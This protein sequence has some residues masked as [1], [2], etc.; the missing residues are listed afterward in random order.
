[1]RRKQYPYNVAKEVNFAQ[2][3]ANFSNPQ[4]EF[5]D[6]LRLIRRG[7]FLGS[8][9]NQPGTIDQENISSSPG[10]NQS[11]AIRLFFLQSSQ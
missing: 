4:F 7:D 6:F 5:W 10:G 3:L 9:C 11:P 8:L 1:M 2:G